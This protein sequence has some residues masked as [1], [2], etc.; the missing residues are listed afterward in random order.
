[1]NDEF[2]LSEY[3]AQ[4]LAARL[5]VGLSIITFNAERLRGICYTL[6]AFHES[7]RRNILQEKDVALQDPTFNTKRMSM[8]LEFFL[9]MDGKYSTSLIYKLILSIFISVDVFYMKTCSFRGADPSQLNMKGLFCE[10]DEPVVKYQMVPCG[11]LFCSCCYYSRNNPQRNQS[12]TPIDFSTS[13]THEFVNGY[14]TY[15]NCPAVCF[16]LEI[17]PFLSFASSMN[18][19]CINLDL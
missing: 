13:S 14:T 10:K 11:D 9:Q 18:Y 8:A 3:D 17:L 15:L 2:T 7:F 12:W 4:E 19:F 1:M 6:L 16:Y 5:N